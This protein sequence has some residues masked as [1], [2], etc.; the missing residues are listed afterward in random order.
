M[1]SLR[2]GTHTRVLDFRGAEA[3]SQP[4]AATYVF[5]R[6][7]YDS[8]KR[9]KGYFCLPSVGPTHIFTIQVEK[10]TGVL[11]KISVM[12]THR[13]FEVLVLQTEDELF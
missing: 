12:N 8:K 1:R 13:T 2:G 3:G 7:T 5:L 9:S 10:V 11:N 4:W 6:A